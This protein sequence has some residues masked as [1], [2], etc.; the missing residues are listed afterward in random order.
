MPFYITGP[1]G[2]PF[3]TTGVVDSGADVS[4]FPSDWAEPLG[5]QIAASTDTRGTM[6]WI[7]GRIG[8][9]HRHGAAPDGAVSC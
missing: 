1:N 2:K 8:L 6:L 5:I 3:P 4:L 9:A 7:V